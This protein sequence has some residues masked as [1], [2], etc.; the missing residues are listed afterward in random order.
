MLSFE[1]YGGIERL[2]IHNEEEMKM[3]QFGL[4]LYTIRDGFL[5]EEGVRDSFLKMAEYGYSSGQTAGEYDFI[6]PEKYAAYAKDAGIEICGTHYS[7]Q[8]I[9]E[10][11]D[12]TMR[13]HEI[14]G[15]TNI[16]IGAMPL[17]ICDSLDAVKRFIDDV[18]TV[19]A[20]LATRGFKFTYHNHSF[21]FKKFNGKTMMDYLIEGFDPDNVSFVL[22]T[23]WV[24]HGGYDI[25][26][27]IKRLAG[28]VDILHLKDMG[29]CQSVTLADGSALNVPYITEIGNGNL[30][31]EDIIPLA[32]STGV[33]YF[34]VEQDCN[35][36]DG[37]AFHSIK[38]S[39]DYIKANLL[40]K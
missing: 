8:R 38:A 14:L 3:K 24:Q 16:G 28:R 17:E 6:A 37:D 19:A 23:Y 11:T 12:E 39:A 21:E 10:K 36:T 27:M 35:F 31:F 4:Q 5:T 33:K 7:W 18:N 2:P 32:E 13:Y 9:S 22:D 26:K 30:N 25:C 1:R 29:A 15:T 20:K 34:V 40:N